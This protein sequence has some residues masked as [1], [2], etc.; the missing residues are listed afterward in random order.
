[1]YRSI[2]YKG[3]TESQDKTSSLGISYFRPA[4]LALAGAQKYIYIKEKDL[5]LLFCRYLS[6][7]TF[8]EIIAKQ[9]DMDFYI[10]LFDDI[11]DPKKKIKR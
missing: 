1:V 11:S 2:R 8:C 4:D 5:S 10:G 7:G 6:V 9:F 3:N